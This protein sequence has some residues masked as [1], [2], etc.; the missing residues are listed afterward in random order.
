MT[1]S[2]AAVAKA[3]NSGKVSIPLVVTPVS[4]TNSSQ[5][6]GVNVN[7]EKA[8]LEHRSE[9]VL[10]EIMAV[11]K[12]IAPLAE[13]ERIR[14]YPLLR[15]PA[16]KMRT[17]ILDLAIEPITTLFFLKS[18]NGKKGTG[19]PLSPLAKHP[20]ERFRLDALYVTLNKSTIEIHSGPA[21]KSVQQWLASI[22]F[23]AIEGDTN[24]KTG[25]DAV[26][27]LRFPFFS[28]FPHTTLPPKAKNEDI[29]L[30]QRCKN[31]H[32]VSITFVDGEVSDFHN[33]DGYLPKPLEQIHA[34]YRLDEM[35]KLKNLK[36]LRLAS[37]TTMRVYDEG[38]PVGYEQAQKLGQWF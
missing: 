28:R 23:K 10:E 19:L 13:A 30:M 25:L 18:T 1:E 5:Y 11:I 20:N 31:L 15:L 3:A 2:W 36:H 37:R 32:T 34:E 24:Y 26:K 6:D 27:S 8:M 35:F 33:L 12:G 29:V 14:L 4:P 22:N 7:A 38:G 9:E 21:N 16:F 17:K